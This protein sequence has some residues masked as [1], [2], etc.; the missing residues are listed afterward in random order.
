MKRILKII[1]SLLVLAAAVVA[2][3][4]ITKS[5]V[6]NDNKSDDTAT[7]ASSKS[8]SNNSQNDAEDLDYLP[9]GSIVTLKEGD[10]TKLMIIGRMS[11]T[12]NEDGEQGYYDYSAVIYPN[13]VEDSD[14]ML[15]FNKEDIK[16]TFYTGFVD[17][18]ERDFQDR[19][20]DA[21]DN[22]EIDVPRFTLDD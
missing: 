18:Q 2:T 20:N 9:I 8:S 4:F 7:A 1:G 15:F 22:D 17:S 19:I 16:E 5:V 11:I 3:V 10:G 6:E 13:G 12:E 21:V 14:Q